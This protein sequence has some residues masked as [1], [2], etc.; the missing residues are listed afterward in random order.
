MDTHEFIKKVPRRIGISY[1]IHHRVHHAVN[2]NYI[3][4]NDR[5]TFIIWDRMFGTFQPE[6]EQAIYSITKPVKSFNP[7]ETFMDK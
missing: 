2:D 3:D 4:K 6:N 1:P 7:V 5:S